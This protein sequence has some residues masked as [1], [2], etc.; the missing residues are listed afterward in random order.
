MQRI[1]LKLAVAVLLAAACSYAYGQNG[2]GLPNSTPFTFRNQ[3]DDGIDWALSMPVFWTN[4]DSVR[5]KSVL[6]NN[7]QHALTFEMK[8]DSAKPILILQRKTKPAIRKTIDILRDTRSITIRRHA[9]PG[10]R[11]CEFSLDLRRHF[12]KLDPGTYRIRIIWPAAGFSIGNLPSYKP[13][14]LASGIG[15]FWVS[16]TSL[17][18]ANKTWGD[19][20]AHNPHVIL[21]LEKPADDNKHAAARMGKL[22]NRSENTV[23]V[24]FYYRYDKGPVIKTP[25]RPKVGW[26]KWHPDASSWI[27]KKADLSAGRRYLYALGPGKSVQL[28]LPNAFQGL[29][30]IY[31]Y[32]LPTFFN[33][34]G[35][36]KRQGSFF[37]AD[38]VSK[39]LKNTIVSKWFVK[40]HA[41]PKEDDKRGW[42]SFS[43]KTPIPF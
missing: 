36:I 17:D 18:I 4:Y 38:N 9:L 14:R 41:S 5:V 23:F 35:D 22:T 13:R 10:E 8:D 31:T 28:S 15:E 42:E 20:H 19:P 26:T 37:Y 21:Q 12:G 32:T 27:F 43:R 34:K 6:A 1:L 2:V 30:G 16:A 3:G 25:L 11:F 24:P 33:Y 40:E 29:D 39:M 7:S